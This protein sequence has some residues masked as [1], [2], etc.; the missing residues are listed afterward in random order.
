MK[1][2]SPSQMLK[3]LRSGVDLYCPEEEIYIFDYND[4]GAVCLYTVFRD[5]AE[6]LSKMAKE[7]DEYWSAFLGPNGEV[8]DPYARTGFTP[9]QLAMKTYRFNWID[10]KEV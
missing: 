6:E 3:T 10:C 2:G 9:W 4:K 1:F 5:E 8:Y 7:C